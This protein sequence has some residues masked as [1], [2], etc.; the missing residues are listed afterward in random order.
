MS[1]LKTL[2]PEIP[3][4]DVQQITGANHNFH[5]ACME[6]RGSYGMV[7][8]DERML[9]KNVVVKDFSKVSWL[10]LLIP[11]DMREVRF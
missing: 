6:S 5:I 4:E 10:L 11:P 1:F 9:T 7:P 2:F 3:S 8:D